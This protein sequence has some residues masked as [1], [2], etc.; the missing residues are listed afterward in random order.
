MGINTSINQEAIRAWASTEPSRGVNLVAR[1]L[2][3]HD[4]FAAVIH[5]RWFLSP[6]LGNNQ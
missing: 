1:S 6:G 3:E 4:A 5:V 2:H